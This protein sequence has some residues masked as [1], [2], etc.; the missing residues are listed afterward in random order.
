[1]K[2]SL[3]ILF[4]LFVSVLFFK[5]DSF[6]VTPAANICDG[7]AFESAQAYNPQSE[8]HKIILFENNMRSE[9]YSNLPEECQGTYVN[10]DIVGCIEKNDKIELQKCNYTNGGT[11]TRKENCVKITL[12]EASTGN[13][14]ASSTFC[15]KVE[16][17]PTTISIKSDVDINGDDVKYEDVE[18]WLLGY[19]KK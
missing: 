9:W 7:E 15:G 11:R 18:T 1:M 5:C 4:L 2:L 12:F 8:I 13:Q 6:I 14:I 16:A 17:C 3:Y 19:L 10:F